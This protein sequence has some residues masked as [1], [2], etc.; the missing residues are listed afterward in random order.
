M[1][2]NTDPYAA[3]TGRTAAPQ[4]QLSEQ[5]P[6]DQ[7]TYA[8]FFKSLLY[9][10]VFDPMTAMK[11]KAPP[12]PVRKYPALTPEQQA[13][14]YRSM[15][16]MYDEMNRGLRN[17]DAIFNGQSVPDDD[18]VTSALGSSLLLQPLRGIGDAVNYFRGTNYPHQPTAPTASPAAPA[19]WPLPPNAT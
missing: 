8:Q 15:P 2:S 5:A 18:L 7:P 19:G 16:R 1:P 6:A 13:M 17:I 4:Q 9:N 14:P 10:S 11:M 3:D 12:L